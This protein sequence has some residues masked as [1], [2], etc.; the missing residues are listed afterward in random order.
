MGTQQAC[1]ALGLKHYQLVTLIRNKSIDLPGRDISGAYVWTEANL[2]QIR[3]VLAN[4]QK[5]GRRRSR[6]PA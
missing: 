1:A 2:A 5:Y 6:Q 3:K 4:R